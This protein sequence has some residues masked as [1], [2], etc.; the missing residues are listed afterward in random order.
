[1]FLYISKL[2]F[3]WQNSSNLTQRLHRLPGALT[4]LLDQLGHLLE[5]VDARVAHKLV[6]PTLAR[7][8]RRAL[9]PQPRQRYRNLLLVTTAHPVCEHVHLV[10]TPQQI[11]RGLRNADMALDPHDHTGHG[12]VRFRSGTLQF[13]KRG[14]DFRGEHGEESFVDVAG[15]GYGDLCGRGGIQEEFRAGFTQAGAVLGRC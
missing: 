8:H 13:L 12:R 4:R 2:Y 10:P 1:M 15:G 7:R 14:D 3:A 5:L 9:C 6:Q 11:Q